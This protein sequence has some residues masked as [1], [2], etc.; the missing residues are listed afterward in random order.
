MVDSDGPVIREAGA[1]FFGVASLGR[2]QVRGNG[3]LVL[4]ADGLSFT[5]WVPKKDFVF[6][7]DQLLR[8]EVVRSHLGKSIFRKLLKLHFLNDE[9]VEDSVAWYVKELDGWVEALDALCP[10]S[11]E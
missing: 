11:A 4:R 8:V 9:G 5:R 1:N 6:P 3:T 10:A 2:R 7:R